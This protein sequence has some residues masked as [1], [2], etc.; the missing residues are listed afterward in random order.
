MVK[1]STLTNE[2]AVTAVF[3]CGWNVGCAQVRS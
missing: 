1:S 2:K 3:T